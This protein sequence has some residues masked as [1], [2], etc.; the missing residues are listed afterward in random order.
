MRSGLLLA[1]CVAAVLGATL[2]SEEGACVCLAPVPKPRPPERACFFSQGRLMRRVS[3]RRTR[4]TVSCSPHG[5][6]SAAPQRETCTANQPQNRGVEPWSPWAGHLAVDTDQ[7]LLPRRR[8]EPHVHDGGRGAWGDEADHRC[9]ASVEGRMIPLLC[10]RAEKRSRFGGPQYSPWVC[11]SD[12]Y[13]PGVELCSFVL[14]SSLTLGA[15]SDS[16]ELCFPVCRSLHEGQR[17]G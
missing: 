16:A 5:V 12:G 11:E 3:R 4:S 9:G 15:L 7:H 13:E 17:E 6:G 10:L 8:V 1:A 2:A 14:A